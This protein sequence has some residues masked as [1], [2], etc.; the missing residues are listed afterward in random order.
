VGRP[1]AADDRIGRDTTQHRTGYGPYVELWAEILIPLLALAGGWFGNSW[2]YRHDRQVEL[3]QLRQQHDE[4]AE[5]R[6]QADAALERDREHEDRDWIDRAAELCRSDDPQARQH[7][8]GFLVGLAAMG[9]TNPRVVDLLDQV[10]QLELG[11][12]VTEIRRAQHQDLPVEVIEEVEVL[13]D[14]R[15]AG[16][17]SGSSGGG[18]AHDGEDEAAEARQEGQGDQDAGRR[19]PG[20]VGGR[21][22]PRPGE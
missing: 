1:A 5:A 16:P 8:R 12:T 10:T 3:S 7:G 18:T 22:D 6:R 13:D 19:R 15:D 11:H 17:R 4:L 9:N 2:R 14:V 20:P 21:P